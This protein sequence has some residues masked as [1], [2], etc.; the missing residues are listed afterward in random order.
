[1]KETIKELEAKIGGL[2]KPF[3]MPGL[4]YGTPAVHCKVG[5]LLRNVK[6][7][8]CSKCYARKGMYVFGVV[9]AAQ[10]RRLETLK[11][12][13]SWTDTM[14]TLLGRKYAKK[15]GDDAVF[16]WHDSGDVQSVE[17]FEAIVQIA[18]NL[19][20][21]QF[22]IPTKEYGILR[23]WDKKIPSNLVVRVSAPMI[24]TAIPAIPGTLSST[25]GAASGFQCGAY[26]RKGKCGPCRAC[27]DPQ[28]ESV[29]YPQH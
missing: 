23:K 3:K 5:S 8:V 14:T 27:W 11:N 25:V 28:I 21:I 15:T 18:K 10:N 1:M 24:G 29:N 17:H 6:G 20:G 2:S 26:T 7:S 12:L 4:A 13:P 19:P 16:R 9:K 22:W